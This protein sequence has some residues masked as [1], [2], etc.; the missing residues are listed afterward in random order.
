MDLSSPRSRK[1]AQEDKSRLLVT[2]TTG[3]WSHARCL[4]ME[5]THFL[6]CSRQRRILAFFISFSDDTS[7]YLRILRRC[8]N[9]TCPII[10]WD[11]GWGHNHH[12][13]SKRTGPKTFAKISA[14]ES[15]AIITLLM[16][17]SL[18]F[19]FA[20]PRLVSFQ[21]S[22]THQISVFS[23]RIARYHDL[24]HERTIDI[25]LRLVLFQRLIKS[26]LAVD[27]Y[28]NG[29]RKRR[30]ALINLT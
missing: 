23:I 1:H 16:H 10:G 15:L 7:Y 27:G 30:C 11:D 19:H 6:L 24:S 13:G 12:A 28:S 21:L 25:S 3:W 26:N 20:S 14:Y 2:Q 22:A 17:E 5:P 8:S 29:I 18:I 4:D 9:P